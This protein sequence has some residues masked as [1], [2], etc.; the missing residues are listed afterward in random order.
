ML[1][2]VIYFGALAYG[3]VLAGQSILS[4]L[5]GSSVFWHGFFFHSPPQN[6]GGNG[7][8]PSCCVAR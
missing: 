5:G 1:A 3:T 2:T 6:G 4:M 8:V 7:R